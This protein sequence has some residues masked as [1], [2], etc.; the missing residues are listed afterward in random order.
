M[1]S[2]TDLDKLNIP[3]GTKENREYLDSIGG[4]PGL[5]S[6]LKTSGV[7]GLTS[8]GVIL[9]RNT[10]GTN[11][12]PESPMVSFFELFAE[13]FM[14]TTLIILICAAFVSLGIGIWEDPGHGWIEGGAILIAVFLVA[15]VTAGNDYTKE[16]QF[17][18]LEASSQNDERCSAIRDGSIQRINPRDLVVGD[19]VLLQ[20]CICMMMKVE[21]LLMHQLYVGWRHGSCRFHHMRS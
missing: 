14:D 13:A 16:L 5:I 10:Y 17:R 2:Q 12:F 3:Q 21:T 4:V 9:M 20:V 15:S 6:K 11:T 7:N 18:S 19:V 8:D 1:L